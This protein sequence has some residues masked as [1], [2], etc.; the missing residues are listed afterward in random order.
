MFRID[1]SGVV[2]IMFIKTD[3]KIFVPK[4]ID[5]LYSFRSKSRSETYIRQSNNLINSVNHLY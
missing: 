5:L 4:N 1:I 3:P 2:L